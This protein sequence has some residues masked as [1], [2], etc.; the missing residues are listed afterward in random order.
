MEAMGSAAIAAGIEAG[1]IN[2]AVPAEHREMMDL[3]EAA[4]GAQEVHNAL[5]IR[6]EV[7]RRARF[8]AAPTVVEEVKTKLRE[9]GHPITLFGEGPSDRRDR[10]KAALAEA[11][12]HAAVERDGLAVATVAVSG[13]AKAAGA[14]AAAG[15]PVAFHPAHMPAP[16]PAP[17]AAG[18]KPELFYT[19]AQPG[20][21]EARKRIVAFSFGAAERRL[22]AQ[23]R[24]ASDLALAA[25]ADAHASTVCRTLHRMRPSLSAVADTR[26]LSTCALTQDG[27]VLA[28]GSWGG[29]VRLWNPATGGQYAALKGHRERIVGIAWHPA[30]G[31]DADAAGAG[32]LCA[33][34]SADGTARLWSVPM[35]ALRDVANAAAA[36]GSPRG[37]ADLS[38]GWRP[39][40]DDMGGAG[41]GAGA[42]S[43]GDTTAAR[44]RVETLC[45]NGLTDSVALLGHGARLASV[46]WHPSGTLLGT[47]SYD[48]TWRLWDVQTGTG[49]VGTC[50]QVQDGH[51]KEVYPLAFHPDGSLVATGD[52]SGLGRVWDLRSG[53]SIFI[54]RGH[55]RSLLALDWSPSGTLI[56]SGSDDNSA[57]V[58]DLRA[59]RTLYTLPAHAS[60]VS[61][62]KFA[63]V[64][65]EY[66]L[67]ASYDGT[68]KAWSTRDWSPLATLT[69]HEGKVTGLDV[70][71]GDE[72]HIVTAGFDRT[73]KTW[74]K[75]IEF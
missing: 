18:A 33:S 14:G 16:A 72:A 53:K 44:A 25:A 7:V 4:R 2:T 43:S 63:P 61:R 47:T 37:L 35:E 28:V 45:S 73:F 54:L 40:D 26:P 29:V 66:L 52:L 5:L 58:W 41:A 6:L 70:W 23:G 46:A 22:A 42:G 17:V 31:L 1:N 51:A 49:V 8:I 24:E 48:R 13:E 12:V 3:S 64:S 39:A 59:Q 65:G 36:N 68:V 38:R 27:A 56:A 62:V 50:V 15:P 57:S 75:A 10:L 55:T 67:T 30:A 21:L 69:G 9:L 32:G 20:L 34:A 19:P 11:D 71:G 60:L 74:A